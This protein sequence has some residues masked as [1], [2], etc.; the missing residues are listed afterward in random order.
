MLTETQFFGWQIVYDRETTVNAYQADPEHCACAYCRNFALASKTL[1]DAYYQF[2]HE[3]G[4]DP[5]KVA[6]AVEYYRNPDGSHYYGWW[7]H[8]VGNIQT[9]P[10]VEKTYVADKI[11]VL[12]KTEK[13]LV[14]ASFPEPVIQV[15]FFTNLPWLL[16]EANI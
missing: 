3:L 13:H 14:M 16:K 1:P 15:E 12:F 5:D 4:I 9:G 2:L 11:Q 7:F 6:E 8:V 10:L